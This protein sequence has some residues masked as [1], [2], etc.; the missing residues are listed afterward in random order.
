[1]QID[2]NELKSS[3]EATTSAMKV[4]NFA[5]NMERDRQFAYEMNRQS[6]ERNATL[7]AGAKANIEQKELIEQQL[8]FMQQQNLL[9]CDNYEQLKNMYD[10]QVQT[11]L[12]SKEALAQ[13]RKYNKWMM[14]VSI[15]AMLAA[16]VSP[17]VTA[18]V[19]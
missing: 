19:S 14:A 2:L 17:I 8:E 13:S 15:I 6:A 16:V 3:I 9:L 18:L 4:A 12:E 1:M 7:V 5:R 10:N 11:N